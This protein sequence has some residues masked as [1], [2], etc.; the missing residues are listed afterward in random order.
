MNGL[1]LL[2]WNEMIDADP[3]PR[4]NVLTG[5]RADGRSPAR[6]HAWFCL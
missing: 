2:P 6:S 4:G 3:W 5:G 1:G